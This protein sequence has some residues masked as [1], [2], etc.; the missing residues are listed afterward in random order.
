M[1][2]HFPR[3]CRPTLVLDSWLLWG[4]AWQRWNENEFQAAAASVLCLAVAGATP[5]VYGCAAGIALPS[6]PG[7]LLGWLVAYPKASSPACIGVGVLLV[8]MFLWLPPPAGACW[9]CCRNCRSCRLSWN[10]LC[11]DPGT[12]MALEMASRTW[13]GSSPCGTGTLRSCGPHVLRT[14][15]PP[16]RCAAM[17]I[18]TASWSEARSLQCMTWPY[19]AVT[20]LVRM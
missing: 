3:S 15:P 11:V 16:P 20:P 13:W 14:A 10:L 7:L 4:V 6:S 12:V 5:C 8:S 18:C 17:G 19:A 2:L 1:V 9:A